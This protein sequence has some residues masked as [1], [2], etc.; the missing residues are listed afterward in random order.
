[1]TASV[2]SGPA[3]LRVASSIAFVGL[4]FLYSSIAFS[5]RYHFIKSVSGSPSFS[6]SRASKVC[7]G[8]PSSSS[9]ASA[10]ASATATAAGERAGWPRAAAPRAASRVVPALDRGERRH[11]AAAHRRAHRRVEHER[12]GE[13]DE[14]EGRAN[15]AHA[16]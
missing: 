16:H 12:V 15:P 14:R 5:V 3:S 7:C 10:G 9:A 8:W 6:R 13:A 11:A 4:F 1:M 2:D